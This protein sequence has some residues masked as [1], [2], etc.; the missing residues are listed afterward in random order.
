MSADVNSMSRRGF[1]KFPS[2]RNDFVG[3]ELFAAPARS[4]ASVMTLTQMLAGLFDS[5]LFSTRGCP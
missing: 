1:R 5:S 4:S 2:A 3:E